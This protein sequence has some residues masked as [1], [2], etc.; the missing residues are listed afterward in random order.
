MSTTAEMLAEVPLFA[1][2]DD[3]E[4]AL[5]AERVDLIRL[6]EGEVLFDYGDPGDYMVIVKSG[7]VELTVKT[8][9][10]EKVFLER[11]EPGDFFGEISL[12]D[13]GSR[14]AA[15]TV[16]ESGEAIVVD[17]EDLDELVRIKPSAAMHLLKATGK[18]LRATQTILRNTATRN[19]NEAV[20]AKSNV[21]LRAA[22]LVAGF[23]GSIEFL[24]LH[25]GIF[26]AWIV[27]NI[28]VLPFGNFD[29]FPFGL[30]TMWVSLEAIMLSTLL[31]FSSNRAAASDKI[32]SDIEYDVN[33]KAELQIQHLHEKVDQLRMLT[34]ARLDALDSNRKNP[35]A[36]SPTS[37]A[38]T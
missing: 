27:C 23:S 31:L 11:A 4:R 21:V 8:K 38:T 24:L 36:A 15:A 17:R 13:L 29:P 3:K 20:A 5:L 35:G 22:D 34:L 26:A 32:R 28:G 18:R 9:T 14:T 16:T 37:P 2:F 10:G 30:L 6:V 33:L 12:L 1:A 7:A 25:L 19:A